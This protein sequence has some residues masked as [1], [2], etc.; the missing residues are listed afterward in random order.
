LVACD[1]QVLAQILEEFRTSS[2]DKKLAE[3]L[4]QQARLRIALGFLPPGALPATNLL[5]RLGREALVSGGEIE[6]ARHELAD[7][8]GQRPVTRRR[9]VRKKSPAFAGLSVHRGAEI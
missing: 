5:A 8:T 4:G 9:H 3:L 7:A 2:S 6:A 1:G